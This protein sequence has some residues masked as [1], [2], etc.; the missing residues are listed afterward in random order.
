MSRA[1]ADDSLVMVM[2][3]G[4]SGGWINKLPPLL[5]LLCC[6]CCCGGVE[7]E[8]VGDI[9]AGNCLIRT[10]LFGVQPRP[11]QQH[12]QD[13]FLF[14]F[15]RRGEEENVRRRG[16]MTITIITIITTITAAHPELCMG[17]NGRPGIVL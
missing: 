11:Q 6:C 10:K 9:R 12:S 13:I 15:L 4:R 3:P 16:Q 5:L 17:C 14:P 2:V 8:R 7:V 1:A